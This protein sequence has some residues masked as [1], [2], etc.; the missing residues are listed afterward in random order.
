ML[1]KYILNDFF[2]MF[3]FCVKNDTPLTPIWNDLWS[4]EISYSWN[5]CLDARAKQ[6]ITLD[7]VV[8]DMRYNSHS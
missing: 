1:N 6:S 8:I 4:Q 7:T 5:S 2:V 3:S